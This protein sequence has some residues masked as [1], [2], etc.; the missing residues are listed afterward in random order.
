MS[1]QA[2]EFRLPDIGEGIDGADIL[3]WRVAVGDHVEEDQ[4]LVEVQTDKAIVVIPS[5]ATGT[6]TA[7]G[8]PEGERLAVVAVLAVID[9]TSRS[10][11]APTP[12]TSP[13]RK[14]TAADVP[15]SSS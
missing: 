6:V 15:A 7:L 12:G 1:V 9:A 4:E 2:L 13:A 14:S 10:R 11:R 8:A 3:E 5:P